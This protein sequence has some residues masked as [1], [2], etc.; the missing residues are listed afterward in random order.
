[1]FSQERE[2]IANCKESSRQTFLK[3]EICQ[4][5]EQLKAEKDEIMAKGKEEMK[6]EGVNIPIHSGILASTRTCVAV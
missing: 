1:M 3:L 5:L 6:D 4:K 2:K